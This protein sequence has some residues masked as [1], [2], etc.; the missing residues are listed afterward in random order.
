MN[1]K[2]KIGLALGAG[3]A[4]GFCHVGA[5][6][7]LEE[8]GIIPDIVT[9][10]SM[11]AVIGGAY[12]AG[13]SVETLQVLSHIATNRLVRDFR[14]ERRWLGLFAGARVQKLLVRQLGDKRIEDCSIPFACTAVDLETGEL[15][16]F[17]EGVLY[18][19]IRASMSIP[20]VFQPFEV[21]GRT[22][23]DGGVLCR[24]PITEARE[25]GADIVIAVDA[26]GPV[27]PAPIP[28]NLLN[29]IERF[30][31][32]ADWGLSKEA[33]KAADVLLAPELPDK[34]VMDFKNN[35]PTIEAGYKCL[36]DNMDAIKAA[37]GMD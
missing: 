1:K 24:V 25:M 7:A 35:G 16:I 21:D 23:I 11:G 22:Y 17:R 9:G 37:I 26:Q 29:M 12:A 14:I 15:K 2:R 31:M 3:G 8:N 34:S 30:W 33:V 18:Q 20:V 32:I 13:L 19:A 28:H 4:R 6:R 36:I 10:S 27:K 5:L